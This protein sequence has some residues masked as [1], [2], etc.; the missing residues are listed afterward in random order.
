MHHPASKEPRPVSKR[1]DLDFEGAVC[2]VTVDNDLKLG[3]TGGNSDEVPDVRGVRPLKLP[4]TRRG[5]SEDNGGCFGS[6]RCSYQTA[7][8]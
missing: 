1:R 7:N 5:T 6:K 2:V 8:V 4:P 3:G